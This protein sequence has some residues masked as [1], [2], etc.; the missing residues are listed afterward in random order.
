METLEKGKGT[1][2]LV[3][4]RFRT[5]FCME[6]VPFSGSRF[7]LL[8]N[9]PIRTAEKPLAWIIHMDSCKSFVRTTL[10]LSYLK[11]CVFRATAVSIHNI[12][13]RAVDRARAINQTQD[14]SAIDYGAPDEIFQGSRPVLVGTDL[15][16]TYCYLLEA[17][18]R[19]S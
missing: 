13:A 16:S 4:S 8:N 10:E 11:H 5:L 15:Q 9:S 18:E 12:T 1:I 17:A 2:R 14:L 19:A 3:S 7:P 6:P